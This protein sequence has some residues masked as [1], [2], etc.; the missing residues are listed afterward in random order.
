MTVGRIVRRAVT[1]LALVGAVA[2]CAQEPAELATVDVRAPQE[3]HLIGHGEHEGHLYREQ[4]ATLAT[5][6]AVYAIAY[7]ACVDEAHAPKVAYLEGYLGMPRP[8]SCNWYHSGFMFV[9]INGRD[10][11]ITPLSSMLA[12]EDGE[13]AMVDLVWH[14]EAADV[15][16]RFAAL[17]GRDWLGCEV[18]LDPADEI[19]SVQIALRCYPSFFTAWH[20][21]DGARR[22][23]TPSHLIEQG[24]DTTLPADDAWWA[25]YYDEVFDVAGGEGEGPCA[26]LVLPEHASQVRFEP[27]GYA[28]STRVDVPPGVRRIRMAFWDLEG[29]GNADALAQI[30]GQAEPVARTLREMDFTPRAVREFDVEAVR[31]SVQRALQS[32]TLR[33]ALS[34][35]IE[36][37]QAWLHETSQ[38]EGQE[39]PESIRAQERLLQSVDR[40]NAFKWRVKLLELI[41][42]L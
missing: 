37:I 12:S 8:A 22:I 41:E 4:T 7:K 20:D 30:E 1:L 23:R 9:R 18:A 14:D 27:G 10:I 2:A 19:E 28:V 33:E 15:R 40:Y 25:L 24:D 34:E 42:D 6:A 36:Q 17:G 39:R 11:G 32:E 3:R 35:D 31:E 26:M 16:V 21:R 29:V 38:V 5:G 13:R